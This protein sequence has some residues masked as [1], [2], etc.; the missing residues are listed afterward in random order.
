V[1]VVVVVSV[2]SA[3]AE[4]AAPSVVNSGGGCTPHG[5]TYR[6]T[7]ADESSVCVRETEGERERGRELEMRRAHKL[8]QTLYPK[9]HPT[10]LRTR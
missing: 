2:W 6:Y 4:G 1:A 3:R 10:P 7:L 8:L 5:R 9:V